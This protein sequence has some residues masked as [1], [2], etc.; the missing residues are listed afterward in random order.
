MLAARFVSQQ[1]EQDFISI[2]F[3]TTA[4]QSSSCHNFMKY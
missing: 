3:E 4:L 2:G 1:G